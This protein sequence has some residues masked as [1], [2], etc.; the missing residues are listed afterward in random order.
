MYVCSAFIGILRISRKC[1][2]HVYTQSLLIQILKIFLQPMCSLT[3]CGFVS[4]CVQSSVVEV[5]M[6]ICFCSVFCSSVSMQKENCRSMCLYLY[7]CACVCANESSSPHTQTLADLQFQSTLDIS[8]TTSVTSNLVV[9]K[10][11]WSL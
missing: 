10:T 4:V 3:V 1:N 5:S 6:C 9:E 11:R 2:I 7:V 8:V